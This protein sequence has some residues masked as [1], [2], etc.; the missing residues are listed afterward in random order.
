MFY[1]L[2]F[3]PNLY[4]SD[5]KSQW[6]FLSRPDWLQ[7]INEAR[8]VLDPVHM[9]L[10]WFRSVFMCIRLDCG[11]NMDEV[12]CVIAQFKPRIRTE[13]QFDR[14]TII[15]TRFCHW[16]EPAASLS[17]T[18]TTTLNSTTTWITVVNLNFQDEVLF[19]VLTNVCRLK[20]TWT[21]DTNTACRLKQEH[22]LL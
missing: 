7:S 4:C 22:T 6:G 18:L 13:T 5:D 9:L 10:R 19:H 12:L 15:F 2:H 11:S 1:V 17:P 20:V 3:Y 8:P 14:C 16:T 21:T